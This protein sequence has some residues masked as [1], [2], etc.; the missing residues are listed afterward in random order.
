MYVVVTRQRIHITVFDL[1]IQDI[2]VLITIRVYPRISVF[3]HI[4][5]SLIRYMIMEYSQIER[6]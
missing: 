6:H 2:Y 1:G 5:N 3:F 4:L